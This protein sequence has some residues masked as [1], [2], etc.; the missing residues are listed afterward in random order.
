MRYALFPSAYKVIRTCGSIG[1]PCRSIPKKHHFGL[2]GKILWDLAL[3]FGIGIGSRTSEVKV[4]EY[5]VGEAWDPDAEILWMNG[6][7]NC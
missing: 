2:R 6:T 3:D 5:T 1:S 4:D 7:Y